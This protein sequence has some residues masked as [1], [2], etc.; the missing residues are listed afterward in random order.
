MYNV[1]HSLSTGAVVHHWRTAS[2]H[3]ADGPY[4]LSEALMSRQLL[5]YLMYYIPVYIHIHIHI[6]NKQAHRAQLMAKK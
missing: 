2:R 4:G 6:R 1:M 3:T 5:I